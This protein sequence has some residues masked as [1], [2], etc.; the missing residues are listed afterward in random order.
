MSRRCFDCR[1]VLTKSLIDHAYRYDRGASI[2]LRSIIKW[3]CACG[4]YEVEIPR[5][6]P[7]HEAIAQ[8]LN[9]LHV[10]R[11]AMSFSFT[12]GPHGVKDGAWGVILRQA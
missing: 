10:K 4:Y 5:M 8:A 12:D 7:L 3:S 6:G 11:D 2:Q 9:V 1:G